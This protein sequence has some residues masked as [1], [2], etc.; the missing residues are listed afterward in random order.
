M[1]VLN[2]TKKNHH[3]V[4]VANEHLKPQPKIKTYKN[5]ARPKF[6]TYL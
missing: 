5:Q 6:Y 4:T 3:R 2:L 1:Y